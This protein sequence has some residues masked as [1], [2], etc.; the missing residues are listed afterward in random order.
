MLEQ[1]HP[2]EL[3]DVLVVD[4]CS[5]DGTVEE[6]RRI[7]AELPPTDAERVRLVT[8]EQRTVPAALNL[9]IAES[10]GRI[11]VRVDG[12]CE[13]SHDYLRGCV[14]VLAEDPR[15]DCVGGVLVTVG[16][17]LRPGGRRSSREASRFGV[18]G[19]S[20]RTGADRPREVDTVAF[21]AYRREAFDRIG[22]FDEELIRNQDDELNFRLVRAGGRIRL[23]PTISARYTA[24]SS[25]RGL[26]R[27]Y[28]QYGYFKARVARKHR[29][30]ATVRQLVPPAFVASLAGFSLLAVAKHRR[31][32]GVLL[33]A[34]GS[35]IGVAAGT[36]ARRDVGT[37]PVLPVVFATMHVAYGAGYL[38]G[39]VEWVSGRRTRKQEREWK[40]SR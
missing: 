28:F 16:G 31:P 33:T 40:L 21:G 25:L 5:D 24:R 1:D 26:A 14:R 7:R 36:T 10:Q 11:L 17:G 30:V 4:G 35:A 29:G 27:Q 19:A 15:V 39:G 9:G 12:H 22:T 2:A 23:E 38:A 8:N 13:L 37:I 18:G 20:F 6:V 3:V 32:L 34:Y